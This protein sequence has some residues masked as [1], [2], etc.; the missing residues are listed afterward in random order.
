MYVSYL[1]EKDTGMYSNPVRTQTHNMNTQNLMQYADFTG[2]HQL[3]GTSDP[4]AQATGVWNPGFPSPR[5]EWNPYIQH[6][7]CPGSSPAAE[8]IG[9]NSSGLT[10]IQPQGQGTLPSLNSSAGEHSPD[11]QRPSYDWIRRSLSSTG[12]KTRTKDKYR[13]VYTDQQRLELEKE[14]QYS[15]YITISR[16]T[17][18][19]LGLSLSERQVKIWFQ[20]RRA[21]ERK[22]T[23]KKLPDFTTT[24]TMTTPSMTFKE[25]Y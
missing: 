23:K 22:L 19:A 1:L 2:Y 7:G 25:E 14:F 6:T 3:A 20:N 21:K 5:E 24:P 9:F 12:G 16:K 8:Q 18:L 15:R 17:E 4:H 11:S 13:V 10:Y